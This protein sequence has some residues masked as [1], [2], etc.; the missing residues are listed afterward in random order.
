[1]TAT[2]LKLRP[3]R[4]SPEEWVRSLNQ[5]YHGATA[6]EVIEAAIHGGFL[7]KVALVSSFGAESAVLLHLVSQVDPSTPVVFLET[8]K[9][10]AQTTSYRRKLAARLGLSDVRDVTPDAEEAASLD[11]KGDL[12]RSDSDACCHLRKVRPLTNALDD[13]DAWF[14]GRK[15]FHGGSRMTLPIFEWSGTHVKVNPLV[16]WTKDDV[17]AHME[18][19][20]LPPHPLVAQGY[21]SIGCWPCTLPSD[22]AS[23]VRAGRW[24]GSKRECGIHQG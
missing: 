8:Q 14:T 4:P 24:S 9:H 1:M 5:D 16:S 20:D 10:F 6:Q 12:W 7:G 21:Q 3:E 2:I 22:D 13:F 15:A 11:P 19:H 17:A 18:A 23:D